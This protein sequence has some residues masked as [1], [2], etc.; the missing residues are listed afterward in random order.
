MQAHKAQGGP[1]LV[2]NKH[3]ITL[4][5]Q[6]PRIKLSSMAHKDMNVLIHYSE[7]RNLLCILCTLY[8]RETDIG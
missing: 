8:L 5:H 2:L 3:Q 6:R 4:N 1:K 7:D